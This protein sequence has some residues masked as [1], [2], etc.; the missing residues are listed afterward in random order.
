MANDIRLSTLAVDA[1]ADRLARLLDFGAIQVCAGERPGE[2]EAVPRD[3]VL[4]EWTLDAPSCARALGGQL[5]FERPP[6]AALRD[7]TPAFVQFVTVNDEAVFD[8]SAGA[9]DVGFDLGTASVRKG[10]LFSIGGD[11]AYTYTVPRQERGA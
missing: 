2:G 4:I 1:Q 3:R 8:D 7:G 11:R 5:R 9:G 6:V 10:D